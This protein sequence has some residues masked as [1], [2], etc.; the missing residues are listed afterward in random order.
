MENRQEEEM[1]EKEKVGKLLKLKGYIYV[2][3][4]EELRD[5][6]N[7]MGIHPRYLSA[8]INRTRNAAPEL[9]LKI[10]KALGKSRKFLFT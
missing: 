3:G 6:A 4:Y 8:I 2:A 9:Q 1:G 7:E 5:F 10:A